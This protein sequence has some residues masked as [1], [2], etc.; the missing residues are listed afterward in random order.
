MTVVDSV[1]TQIGGVVGLTFDGSQRVLA[2]VVLQQDGRMIALIVYPDHF[3][4]TGPSLSYESTDCTG[5]PLF[6]GDFNT[7]ILPGTIE[8]PGSTVYVP[9]TST[10]PQALTA[11]S[12]LQLGMCFP[13]PG[14]FGL[15]SA[16][17]A[18]PLVDLDTLYTP[19]FSLQ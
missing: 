11:K 6:D 14:G 19:P 5:T 7:M 1:G 8:G 4:G 13:V 15:P 3:E 18:V 17:P 10:P 9:D 2:N 12:L 16:I